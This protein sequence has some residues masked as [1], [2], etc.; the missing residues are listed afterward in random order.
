ML[1]VL[2]KTQNYHESIWR[3]AERFLTEQRSPKG[4]NCDV[5]D[6]IR[7]WEVS[8]AENFA[9]CTHINITFNKHCQSNEK[10]ANVPIIK[11]HR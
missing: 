8:C 9:A 3:D 2:N 10:Y 1:P 11:G 5:F 7:F 4:I 6:L